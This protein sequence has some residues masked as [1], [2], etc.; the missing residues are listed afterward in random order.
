MRIP[1]PS[2]EFRFERL[3]QGELLGLL[4]DVDPGVWSVALG[5]NASGFENQ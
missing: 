4:F 1:I 5:G 3:L 2:S